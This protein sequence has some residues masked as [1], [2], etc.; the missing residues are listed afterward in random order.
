M[1]DAACYAHRIGR[2][3]RFGRKGVG[4]NLVSSE[5]QLAD[6]RQI[7]TEYEVELVELPPSKLLKGGGKGGI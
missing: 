6:L 4:I 5:Q 7:C 2:C 1:P 3:G